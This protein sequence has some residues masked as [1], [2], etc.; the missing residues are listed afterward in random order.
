MRSFTALQTFEAPEIKSVY[1]EGLSYTIRE[2]NRY[3]NALAE[4]WALQGKIVFNHNSKD[5]IINGNGI[6]TNAPPILP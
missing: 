6:V 5:K 3:L 2:G 1:V 4:V